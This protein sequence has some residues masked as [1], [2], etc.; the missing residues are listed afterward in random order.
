MKQLFFT[1]ALF[2][3]VF[4]GVKGQSIESLPSHMQ[5]INPGSLLDILPTIQTLEAFCAPKGGGY[6]LKVYPQKDGTYAVTL[7]DREFDFIGRVKI[8]EEGN[9]LKTFP[10]SLDAKEFLSYL[11]KVP[12]EPFQNRL[13]DDYYW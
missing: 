1:F 12:L 11:I 10:Y 2:L 4:F 9:I 13:C 3:S 7:R 8:T 6:Y 5:G